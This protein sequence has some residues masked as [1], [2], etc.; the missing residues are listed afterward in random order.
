VHTEGSLPN[1]EANLIFLILDNLLKNAIQA[2]PRG[3]AVDLTAKPEDDWVTFEVCDEG[4][5]LPPEM[6]TRLFAPCRSQKRRGHGI[7]LAICKQL[8]RHLEARLELKSTS[9]RGSI[10]VLR[11]PR[12]RFVQNPALESPRQMN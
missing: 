11:L 5:G 2:T 7:G 3:Q 9:T 8:A 10:F 4:P 6:Q 12:R 1:R